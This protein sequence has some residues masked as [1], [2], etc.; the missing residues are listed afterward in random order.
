MFQI[1]HTT[2]PLSPF[3]LALLSSLHL[4]LLSKDLVLKSFHPLSM[5]LYALQPSAVAQLA[6]LSRHEPSMV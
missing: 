6:F 3:P 1:A 2:I 4:L 5:Q